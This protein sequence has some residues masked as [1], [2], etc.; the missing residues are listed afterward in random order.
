MDV[1]RLVLDFH[2]FGEALCRGSCHFG[3]CIDEPKFVEW[4]FERVCPKKAQDHFAYVFRIASSHGS[5]F[6]RLL[7]QWSN[8]AVLYFKEFVGTVCGRK[9]AVEVFAAG[10][11]DERLSEIGSSHIVY[12][13]RNA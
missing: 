11:G 2:A 1:E 10:V 6:L 7:L 5:L 4:R 3:P 13:A 8:F 9:Y 12:D